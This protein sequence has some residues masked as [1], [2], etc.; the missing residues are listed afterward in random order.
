MSIVVN[1]AEGA[2]RYSKPDK[3]R[4]HVTARGSTTE[5]AAIFDILL[6]L[7]ATGSLCFTTTAGGVEIWAWNREHLEMVIHVLEGRPASEHPFGYFATY[8]RKRWLKRTRRSSFVRAARA[9][10]APR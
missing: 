4:F 1:V 3:R 7:E 2:G 5:C 6:R 8:L 9:L 10:L